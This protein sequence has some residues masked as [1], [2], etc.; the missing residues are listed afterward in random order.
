MIKP[1]LLMVE[2]W[3]VGDVIIGTPFLLEA[4]KYYQVTLLAKPHAVELSQRFWPE[5]NVISL[6]A[7][8]TDFRRKYRIWEW[9]W[10]RMLKI[11]QSLRRENFLFGVSARWDPRDHALLFAAGVRHRYGFARWGSKHL[12]TVPVELPHPKA[13]RYEYYQR[14]GKALGLI[15]PERSEL[16]LPRSPHGSQVLVHTGAGQTLRVWPLMKYRYLVGQLRRQGYAVQVVC[17]RDQIPWWVQ[18]GEIGVRCPRGLKELIDLCD[19]SAALIGNDSGPGHLAACCGLPTFTIFG[20]QLPGKFA[21]LHPRAEWIE[22]V[23]CPQKPCS[24][25]CRFLEPHCILGVKET[26][27]RARVLHFLAAN[28][29]SMRPDSVAAADA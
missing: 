19:A 5:V 15:L 11:F 17:D 7:P 9:P 26:E 22:G 27:V 25:Y 20:P 16:R 8:W 24:D 28:S 21:P 10:K 4:A 18:A 2:L 1:K 3:G 6:N 13:H 23:E 14:L 29:V 12:I